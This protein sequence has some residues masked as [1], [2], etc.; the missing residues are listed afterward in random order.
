VKA[1][2]CPVEAQ[3]AAHARSTN[4]LVGRRDKRTASR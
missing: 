3:Q 1:E 2:A 4:P